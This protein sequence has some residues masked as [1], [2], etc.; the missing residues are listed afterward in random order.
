MEELQFVMDTLENSTHPLAAENPSR[1][2][3]MPNR[4][5]LSFSQRPAKYIHQ[6]SFQR[7][8]EFLNL[9]FIRFGSPLIF[10][11]DLEAALFQ[12]TEGCEIMLRH[13][14]KQRTPPFLT[15]KLFQ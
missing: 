11:D 10:V 1:S 2:V 8:D 14:C 15:E 4:H 13:M 12:H 7:E 5:F 3:W 9:I 6:R